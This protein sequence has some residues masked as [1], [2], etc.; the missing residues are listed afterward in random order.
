MKRFGVVIAWTLLSGLGFGC[1]VRGTEVVFEIQSGFAVPGDVNMVEVSVVGL[2]ATDDPTMGQGCANVETLR[3]GPGEV[4]EQLPF[5]YAVRQGS[6]CNDRVLLTI[7]FQKDGV[8][9]VTTGATARFVEGES[10]RVTVA[11]PS[12]TTCGPD[13][14]WCGA[15]CVN[16]SSESQACGWC[17]N[18]CH[19]SAMCASRWCRCRPGQSLCG[20]VCVAT[21]D[22]P[23]NCG[24]CGRQCAPGEG[25]FDGACLSGCPTGWIRCGD[26]CVDPA[27]DSRHCGACDQPCG[28][29]ERCQ[30]RVCAACEAPLGGMCNPIDQCGCPGGTRCDGVLNPW[31][32]GPEQCVPAGGGGPGS[33]CFT[34]EEC[35]PG[36]GCTAGGGPVY[37]GEEGPEPPMARG[38][39]LPWCRIDAPSTCP[40]GQC[41]ALMGNGVYGFCLTAPRSET[42]N[43]VDDDWDGMADDINFSGD[44][45]N[46]GWCGNVCG[47]A[48]TCVCG[49]CLDLGGTVGDACG[50]DMMCQRSGCAPFC[51]RS[52]GSVELPNGYCTS[53]CDP[54]WDDCPS[55]SRCA[56]LPVPDGNAFCLRLC[57]DERDC[58]GFDDRCTH[59]A[60]WG[61]SVCVPAGITL[62]TGTP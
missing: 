30:D 20:G 4:V 31:D 53:F 16:P 27:F 44:P 47:P 62:P 1:E 40:D 39:C 23:V 2:A 12:G 34:G 59:I 54:G 15:G 61:E 51:A 33:E 29:M 3:L 41:A 58:G 52:I 25:C 56:L 19:A 35:L 49:N 14:L 24:A 43:G 10:V 50:D 21:K 57:R 17:G 8:T 22:D 28:E 42:C 45:E 55:G 48:A 38:E 5:L 9:R 26:E 46:C 32:F 37:G 60:A 18:V 11:V 13:E 36:L 6:R 7:R